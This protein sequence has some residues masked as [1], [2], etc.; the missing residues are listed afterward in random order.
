MS[1]YRDAL[2]RLFLKGSF[3][4]GEALKTIP[5]ELTPQRLKASPAPPKS[6]D[7][8]KPKKLTPQP[9]SR[10]AFIPSSA[11]DA[12]VST[13]QDHAHPGI[14]LIE[15]LRA[16]G[17]TASDLARDI[18]V[19]VNRVTA[20]INGQRGVTADTALRLGHWFDE[21]PETWLESQQR[22]ELAHARAVSGGE[23]RRLPRLVRSR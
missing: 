11:S 16:H 6:G 7:K 9:P 18:R 19:P 8:P 3:N 17:K 13:I 15:K 22:H 4:K 1:A 20:I 2:T 12:A 23:I 5:E 21:T 10:Q 14:L